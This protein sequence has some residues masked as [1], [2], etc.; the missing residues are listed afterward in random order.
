MNS[1]LYSLMTDAVGSRRSS[2]LLLNALSSIFVGSS[3]NSRQSNKE[4]LNDI[5]SSMVISDILFG[6]D[7]TISNSDSWKENLSSA[8]DYAR[9]NKINLLDDHGFATWISSNGDLLNSLVSSGRFRNH[10]EKPPSEYIAI[11][12]AGFISGKSDPES[13][14]SE[15][16]SPNGKSQYISAFNRELVKSI[17][18]RD[19]NILISKIEDQDFYSKFSY[20]YR[21]LFYAALARKGTLSKKAARKIRS[22]SSDE[23]SA[24]GIK[25]I[26]ENLSKFE[27]PA[28]ILSQ[29]LDTKNY[30]SAH[31]LANNIPY[32]FLPFMAVSSDLSVRK[33]VVDRMSAEANNNP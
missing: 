23:A 2:G 18:T 4:L 7:G 16:I 22:D 10:W 11:I 20:C 28:G 15:R 19:H 32:K 27:D 25:A 31:F 21:S 3:R 30:E 9:E 33:I 29:V 12:E 13:V 26:G 6:L 24:I 5:F 1:D 8:F 17:V 14:F